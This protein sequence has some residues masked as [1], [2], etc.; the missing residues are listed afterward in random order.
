MTTIT[1]SLSDERLERLKALAQK[2]GISPEDLA[3][4]GLEEQL[5]AVGITTR[6][7]GFFNR[8][9]QLIYREPAGRF[10]GYA[11]P[12]FSVHRG[13]L[14]AVLAAAV[15][16]RLGPGRLNLDHACTGVT[17]DDDGATLAFRSTS[18]G[19]PLPPARADIVIACDGI[20]AALRRQLHPAE[21][22]CLHGAKGVSHTV[23]S[24]R[25]ICQA[26]LEDVPGQ[27]A[28]HHAPGNHPGAP[29]GVSGSARWGRAGHGEPGGPGRWAGTPWR[30][31]RGRRGC[32]QRLRRHDAAIARQIATDREQ[33]EPALPDLIH[34][35]AQ[36]QPA[37][38]LERLLRR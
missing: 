6:E 31:P 21:G 4:L 10:A 33:A 20:H 17:Q 37:G 14:H 15:T 8:F 1:I 18:A 13:D 24:R 32:L 30:S 22:S 35:Q 5:A 27:E 7:S 23:S 25:V 36:R 38:E 34:R 2:S 16:A 26:C 12:Q 28:E 19:R 9:G 11:H 29:E 3:R